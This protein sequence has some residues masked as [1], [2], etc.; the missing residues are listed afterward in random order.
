MSTRSHSFYEQQQMLD[1]HNSRSVHSKVF[2]QV[3]QGEG[4]DRKQSMKFSKNL[5]DG[6][7]SPHRDPTRIPRS[8]SSNSMLQNQQHTS[9]IPDPMHNGHSSSKMLSINRQEGRSPV[10]TR[11]VES[12]HT[13]QAGNNSAR[14]SPIPSLVFCLESKDS[15][16]IVSN[17]GC[18]EQSSTYSSAMSTVTEGVSMTALEHVNWHCKI[19]TLVNKPMYL[20]C[21]ACGSERRPERKG[22]SDLNMTIF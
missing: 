19:C 2:L 16:S 17:L 14:S 5:S 1:Y 22:S 18:S 7:L 20:A 13:G 12:G 6:N 21:E 9:A 8:K 10:P 3:P 15:G 4:R 11:P